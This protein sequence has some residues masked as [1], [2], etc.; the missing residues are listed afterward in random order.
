[1]LL[2]YLSRVID[3]LS[4]G[5]IST[6]QAYISDVTTHENRAKGMGLLGAAFGIGFATGPA[7]GGLLGAAH[8]S[9]PA[10]LAAALSTAA[11]CLTWLR[12]PESRVHHE[13]EAEAWLH[14]SR[15]APAFRN[16]LLAQLLL[17]GF[18]SMAGFVMLET[19]AALFL[20]RPETFSWGP[21]R[22]GGYFAFIGVVI[23]IVQGRL[24]GRLSKSIGDWPLAIVG[25]IGVALGMV[26]MIAVGY[27]PSLVVLFLGAAVNA[28]GRS[29]QSPTLYALI[30]KASDRRQQGMVFGLNQGLSSLARVI[31]PVIAGAVFARAITGPYIVAGIIAMITFAW[32]GLLAARYA[33]SVPAESPAIATP[34]PE[35]I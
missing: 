15:F 6:A 17:V 23:V 22:V 9:L 5:N 30:S 1:M 4:G 11:M 32:T 16:P 20:N 13:A 8:P 7:I 12:L 21:G 19:S 34:E 3:G 31:G 29:L 25:P 24:I 2:I 10:F 14:P 33:T 18:L 26:A 28:T 27:H 35:Q